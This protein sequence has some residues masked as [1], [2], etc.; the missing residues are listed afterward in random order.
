MGSRAAR[1]PED[2]Q[3]VVGHAERLAKVLATAE[4]SRAP[5]AWVVGRS[6]ELRAVVAC[7]LSDWREG[8][9]DGDRTR[10]SLASHVDELHRK[11]ARKLRRRVV[12]DCC[13]PDDAITAVGEDSRSVSALSVASILTAVAASDH[14]ITDRTPWVDDPAVLERFASELG[15]IERHARILVRRIGESYVTLDDVRAFGRE[16][17]LDAARSFNAERGVPFSRWAALR[18]RSAMLDGVRRWGPLPRGLRSELQALEAR[19]FADAQPGRFSTRPPSDSRFAALAEPIARAQPE[20]HSGTPEDLFASA[21]VF[22]LVRSMV[23]Q[24][25]SVERTLVEE[26]YLGGKTIEQAAAAAG[27]S[28][29]WGSRLLAR[30]TESMA[31]EL[32]H[33]GAYA[34]RQP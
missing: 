6:A 11:A 30:A 33:L 12:L 9:T 19:D 7:A 8:R 20:Q 3:K 5:G 23:A 34:P 17:L 21:E 1:C 14:A 2:L 15:C 18:V 29:S 4:R 13:G 10:D 16:G 32:R 31:E 27:V 26:H 28:K 24:L 25:P 22:G